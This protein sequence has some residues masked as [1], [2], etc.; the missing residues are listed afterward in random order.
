MSDKLANVIVSIA[1]YSKIIVQVLKL[2]GSVSTSI[3]IVDSK[4]ETDKIINNSFFLVI[5]ANLKC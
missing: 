1:K 3:P 4:V 2:P 5:I